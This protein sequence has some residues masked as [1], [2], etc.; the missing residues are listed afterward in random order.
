MNFQVHGP[1]AVARVGRLVG[2]RA[3]DKKDFWLQVEEQRH[4]LPDACGCYIFLVGKRPWYVGL[5]VNQTFRGEV[6]GSHKINLYNDALNSKKKGRPQ[7]LL[8]AKYHPGR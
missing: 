6:F 4:G 2:H 1:F 7:L 3:R 8:L 5:A